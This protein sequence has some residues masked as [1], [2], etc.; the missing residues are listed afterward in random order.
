MG[1]LVEKC[2]LKEKELSQIDNVIGMLRQTLAALK[3]GNDTASDTL[4]TLQR[5]LTSLLAEEQ[6]LKQLL[7]AGNLDNC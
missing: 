5:D 7:N 4:D 3:K 1:D 6:Q 2:R